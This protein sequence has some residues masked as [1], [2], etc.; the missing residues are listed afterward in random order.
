MTDF[1]Y[2][3]ELGMGTREVHPQDWGKSSIEYHIN[4]FIPLTRAGTIVS[5]KMFEGSEI[6]EIARAP[7]KTLENIVGKDNKHQ[8]IELLEAYKK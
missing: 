1:V 7:L 6:S 4:F 5:V 3:K 2:P 8:R